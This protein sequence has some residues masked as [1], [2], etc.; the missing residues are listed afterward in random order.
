MPGKPKALPLEGDLS[1]ATLVK[2]YAGDIP[3]GALKTELCRAGAAIDLGTDRLAAVKRYPTA[4]SFDEDYVHKLAYSL[5]NLASTCTHNAIAGG[6]GGRTIR[7][8]RGRF[9]RF[10]RTDRLAPDAIR[11]FEYWVRS[12]GA[13]FLEKA[14]HWMGTH[15]VAHADWG[16]TARTD[17]GVGVYYFIED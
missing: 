12:E 9:E 6:A 8:E 13:Q 11:D 10:A 16:S 15:E 14:D 3:P 1:F 17:L 2:R 5:R 4:T 7:L